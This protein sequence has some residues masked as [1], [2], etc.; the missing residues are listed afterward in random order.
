MNLESSPEFD[1]VVI[2]AGFTGMY[3]SCRWRRLGLSVKGIEAGGGVG[4]VW[5]SK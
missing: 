5:Y 1:V 3:R 4:G 2:G